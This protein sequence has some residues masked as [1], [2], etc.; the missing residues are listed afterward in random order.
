MTSSQALSWDGT[1]QMPNAV[2]RPQQP[3][4][5]ALKH[6][7]HGHLYLVTPEGNTL[8][9]DSG[10][11]TSPAHLKIY[12]WEVLDDLV[13]R[14]E[15]GFAE[16]Y[17]K[18][19]WSSKNVAELITFALLNSDA[20]ETF[21]HGKPSYVLWT[22][23]KNWIKPNSLG[24]S[25][26]NVLAHYDL[27]NDFYK[28]W[29]DGSMTYSCALFEGDP[30]RTLEQAQ[31]A[32]YWRILNKLGAK[33][34]DH[35]LEIG[36]GWGGFAEAAARKGVKVTA[37]TLSDEQAAFA[38]ERMEKQGLDNLATISLTDYREVQG[39]F[40]YIVSIG[41]FE[42]VGEKYWPVYFK[43]IKEHLKPGGKAMVQSITLDNEM[44][45][46]LRGVTGF[47]EEVIFPGGMLPS[48]ARFCAAAKESGLQCK[49][50]FAFGKDYMRT[51]SEWLT[52]FQSKRDEVLALGYDESFIRLWKFYLSACIASFASNRSSVMQ[53]ELTH[54]A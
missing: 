29:L 31:Q 11:K 51:C 36:C 24:R 13:A 32:K 35:I 15:M 10:D 44:F 16:A 20:L 27:G 38:K 41:M 28:L 46:K 53:A 3:F 43:A 9:F 50:L 37:I 4:L 39:Q 52:R 33:P 14:G 26:K 23:I 30:D 6:I 45:E 54:A 17:I 12:D 40:D 49:E 5:E 18:G 7:Q 48:Q 25:R 21:L 42:H 8:E 34:G 22:K 2:K 1:I 19:R 47:I